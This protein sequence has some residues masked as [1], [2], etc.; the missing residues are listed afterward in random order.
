MLHYHG[1]IEEHKI[2]MWK[3]LMDVLSCFNDVNY[4]NLWLVN[5]NLKQVSGFYIIFKVTTKKIKLLLSSYVKLRKCE[6]LQTKY[7]GTS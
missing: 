7:R 1:F 4:E 6:F 5:E 3:F 2:E